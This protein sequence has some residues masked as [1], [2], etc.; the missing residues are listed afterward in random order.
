M[1]N[2]HPVCLYYSPSYLTP[3]PPFPL[4][5]RQV[6]DDINQV[7]ENAFLTNK[8]GSDIYQY[9]QD[10]S[11]LFYSLVNKKKEE[12]IV[13]YCVVLNRT[14]ILNQYILIKI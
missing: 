3:L 12:G 8:K 1:Y 9:A 11:S 13:L 6:F 5:A 2:S 4:L 7:W 10:L 14:S